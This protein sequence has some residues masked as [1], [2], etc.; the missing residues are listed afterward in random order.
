MSRLLLI[1]IGPGDPDQV[2]VQAVRA[3]DAFDVLFVVTKDGTEDLVALRR[4]VVARHRTTGPHR[5]VEIPDPPRPWRTAPDYRAAVARWR[6]ERVARWETALTSALG[7]H[8]VGAF[9]VWGDPSLY[10]STLAVVREIADR[11]RVALD[12]E[13][14]PGVSS[15]H[16]LTARHGIALNRVGR[17]VRVSP[18]RLV[19]EQGLPDVDEDVVVVLDAHRALAALPAGGPPLDVYWGAYL[20]TPDEILVAGPLDE[21]RDEI[22]RRR[23][24]ARERKGWIFDIALLRRTG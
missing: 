22:T 23:A 11:G 18:A 13:V 1:G 17:A 4:E 6:E 7:P 2:T 16:A 5:I 9:L 10:E 8:D 12:V 14:V 21:V 3:I 20:G 15:L 24:E 19:A